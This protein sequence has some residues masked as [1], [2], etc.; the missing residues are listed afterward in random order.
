MDEAG[1]GFF[2]KHPPADRFNFGQKQIYWVAVLGGLLVAATGYL[3][4]FPFY[5]TGIV[6]M[7][8]AHLVHGL[9]GLL[10]IARSQNLLPVCVSCDTA[11]S[12]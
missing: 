10:L 5:R 1:G 7:Q 12:I 4:M 8:L 11:G 2:K 9:V 6:A 3:L